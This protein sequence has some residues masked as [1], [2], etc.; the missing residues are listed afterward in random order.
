MFSQIE[1]LLPHRHICDRR[2]TSALALWPRCHLVSERYMLVEVKEGLGC[3]TCCTTKQISHKPPPTHFCSHFWRFC[4]VKGKE[5]LKKIR[6][7]RG[8]RCV[9]AEEGR[10]CNEVSQQRVKLLSATRSSMHLL[11]SCLEKP[12]CRTSEAEILGPMNWSLCAFAWGAA[13]LYI[14]FVKVSLQK[15]VCARA[16]IKNGAHISPRAEL[17]HLF[18]AAWLLRSMLVV[19]GGVVGSSDKKDQVQAMT[20]M[21]P[22][23][24]T[25]S[26]DLRSS[27]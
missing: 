27:V 17:M 13:L 10:K 9:Q 20:S 1:Q 15:S 8:H 14:A 22:F 21:Q 3:N 7:Q 25:Q 11:E 23:S 26:C 19:V 6:K 2:I 16:C 4:G 18:P 5:V 24:P 12:A